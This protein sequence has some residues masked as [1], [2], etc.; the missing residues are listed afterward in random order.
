M[1]YAIALA[2]LLLVTGGILLFQ[3]AQYPVYNDP[4]GPALLS[5]DLA[6]LPREERFDA[7]HEQ[8]K[9]F[10]TPHKH[11]ADLGRGFLAAGF[12]LIAAALL[13]ASYLRRP[14]LRTPVALF[15]LWIMLWAL[16]V[17]GTLWYYGYRQERFDYPVWGD[18]I[19]IPIF[20]EIIAWMIGATLSS[21]L[22]AALLRGRSLPARLAW[23]RP[24]SPW[25]W[26]RVSI[27]LLWLLLCACSVVEGVM[28]GD[29][30]MAFTSLV[31]GG[32]LLIVLSAPEIKPAASKK[33]R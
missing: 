6:D 8:L 4:E 21:L 32:F 10:E 2:T 19:A 29:E 27:L 17:P 3:A 14:R 9:T 24:R 1:K 13:L 22:L 30:G 28:E 7:W 31:A 25:G 23:I 16:R 18:S 15:A 33:Q 12:G 5:N 11:L 20:S 26:T